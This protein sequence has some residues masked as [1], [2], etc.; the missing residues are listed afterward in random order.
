MK[1]LKILYEDKYLIAVSKPSNMLTISDG[2]S[3]NTLYHEVLM[4]LKKK[5]EKVF[6]IH[7]LDKDTSGIVLFAKNY[8]VKDIMQK[9]WL[10]VD[11]VYY[12]IVNGITKDKDT[13]ISNLNE[14]KTLLV[15]SSKKGKEAITKYERE[16][17]N[18][19]Y[20]L[21]KITIK[22]GRKHQIRVQLNDIGHGIVGDKIYNKNKNKVNRMCLHATSLKF[23]HPITNK[24]VIITDDYPDIFNIIIK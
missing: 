16:K 11:R 15:Y 2:K 10:N 4:Y 20:S 1:K 22:T 18:K 17:Y 5:N 24:E 7:R 13:I 19:L 14:T 3:N 23:N 8:K 21:L 12:A 9:N 6:I